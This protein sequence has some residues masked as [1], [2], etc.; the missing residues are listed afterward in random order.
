MY[1]ML[2][3]DIHSHVNEVN[4]TEH[5]LTL[6]SHEIT[7]LLG[8]DKTQLRVP[9][10]SSFLPNVVP[11]DEILIQ[12]EWRSYPQAGNDGASGIIFKETP[13][14]EHLGPWQPAITLDRGQCRI[15]LEVLS[16]RQEKLN[17]ISTDDAMF[18]GTPCTWSCWKGRAPEFALKSITSSY[19]EPGPHLW[20]NRTTKENFRLCW[21]AKHGEESWTQNPTV[22]VISFAMMSPVNMSRK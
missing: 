5:K 7:A 6:L 21:S 10:L 9:A 1:I 2:F 19:G 12:E 4:M 8:L 20:D 14:H 17:D 13:H 15:R 3:A 22:K 11:G 18:E 16:V